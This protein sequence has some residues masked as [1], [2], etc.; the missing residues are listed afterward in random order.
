MCI[1]HVLLASNFPFP[2]TVKVC[3]E[4]CLTLNFLQRLSSTT[5]FVAPES[6]RIRTLIPLG[7]PSS[8]CISPCNIGATSS[9]PCSIDEDLRFS[10]LCFCLVDLFCFSF[11]FRPRE[12]LAFRLFKRL[13]NKKISSKLFNVSGLLLVFSLLLISNSFWPCSYSSLSNLSNSSS[14]CLSVRLISLKSVSIS[15]TSGSTCSN[16][17]CLSKL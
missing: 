12:W 14:S 5:V 16:L 4:V 7:V 2:G 13:C 17:T 11:C 6:T 10:P 15:L 3:F 8:Y 9:S 1:L